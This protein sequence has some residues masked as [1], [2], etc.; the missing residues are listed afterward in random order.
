MIIDTSA[1]IAILDQEPGAERIARAIAAATDRMISAAT[2]VETGIIVQ[3]RR[4]DGGAA[5]RS[6]HSRRN[7]P[8]LRARRSA[9]TAG[10]DTRPSST[11]ATVL[12]TL[13]QR[14]RRRR[15]CS[16]AVIFATQTY[17]WHT[18]EEEYDL[19]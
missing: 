11:S 19:P 6:F 5:S 10:E 15:C 9:D 12:L 1:I 18:S 3:A 14:M 2:L 7:K 4:G 8:T 16:K 17:P 13:W